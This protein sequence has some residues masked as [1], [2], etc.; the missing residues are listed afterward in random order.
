MPRQAT[1]RPDHSH[2]QAQTHAASSQAT[3]TPTRPAACPDRQQQRLQ[4][5]ASIRPVSRTNVTT[6]NNSTDANAIVAEPAV[7]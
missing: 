7:P 5:R 6:K 1:D 4:A 2:A 3:T